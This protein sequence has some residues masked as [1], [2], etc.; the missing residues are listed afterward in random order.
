VATRKSSAARPDGRAGDAPIVEIEDVHV[1]FGDKKVLRGVDLQVRPRETVAILGE[2]GGGKT[3]LLRA[4]LGLQRPDRGVVRL[5]GTDVVGRPE[6]ELEPIR[7]RVS[8]VYQMGALFSGLDAAGNIA[9]E[10]REVLHL[11]ED[12]IER[13][14][15]DSLGAVGLGD[16][17]PKKMPEDLSGGMK[18]RLAVARAIAPNPELVVYDEPVSG[19]DPINSAR[20]LDLIRELHDR[21]GNTSILVTHDVLG[22]C[23]ISTRICLLSGGRFV[24]DGPPHGFLESRDKDVAEFREAV[25]ASVASLSPEPEEHGAA[26]TPR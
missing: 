22:A 5:F 21:R 6:E 17:D 10:L 12:E 20:I 24:Y 19:L 4:M 14:V 2:S 26:G 15:H 7:R 25:K 13:R 18:K 9:L 11:P 3:V 1:S 16:L 8:V 23:R